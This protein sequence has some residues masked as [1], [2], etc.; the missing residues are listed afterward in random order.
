[1]S[2]PV[3][4]PFFACLFP[5]L[6]AAKCCGESAR[7]SASRPN[8]VVRRPKIAK[9]PKISTYAKCIRNS[10]RISTSIF[11]ALKSLWNQHLQKNREGDLGIL[12]GG[13]MRTSNP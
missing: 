10:R 9:H 3:A 2:R 13:F 7:Q 12:A 1:M 11:S 4:S 5:D 6:F 8:T